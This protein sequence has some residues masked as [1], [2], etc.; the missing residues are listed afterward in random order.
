MFGN[1][2]NNSQIKSAMDSQII[3]IKPYS[4]KNLRLAHYAL[5]PA[6]LLEPGLENDKG[7][8][9][10]KPIHNFEV[11][12]DFS[13]KP[14]QYLIV[15]IEQ[16]IFL[17]DGILGQFIPSSTLVERGF[18]ITSGKIDPKY[19]TIKG[20]IQK[21]HFGLFNALDRDNVIRENHHIAH[22]YFVDMRGL[23]NQITD[24]SDIEIENLL[25]ARFPR[26][27]RA[28]DDGVIYDD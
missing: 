3:N 27:R 6:G 24:F 16:L 26:F 4:E 15:E 9:I 25:S 22:V 8:C 12:G 17:E 11:D 10:P 23:K 1:I 21:I 18:T 13:F 2:L 14:K 20:K 5:T 7:R 19:G 28:N